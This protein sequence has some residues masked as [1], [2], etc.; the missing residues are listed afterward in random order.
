MTQNEHMQQTDEVEYSEVVEDE[1]NYDNVIQ[2]HFDKINEYLVDAANNS[3]I[4]LSKLIITKG[5]NFI[6]NAMENARNSG[7]VELEKFIIDTTIGNIKWL[8]WHMVNACSRGH[9]DI[10]KLLII[11]GAN[12]WDEGILAACEN[13]YTD[14]VELIINNKDNRVVEYPSIRT[15]NVDC[16]DSKSENSNNFSRTD[17]DKIIQL[18]NLLIKQN[19]E[20][21]VT[22]Y[23]YN[24]QW[25][26]CL[27]LYRLFTWLLCYIVN[28]FYKKFADIINIVSMFS[29][30]FAGIKNILK[31]RS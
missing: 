17:E 21:A 26:D 15:N 31:F 2:W 27:K 25:E 12:D 20:R 18:L 8:N 19:V 24:N 13:G 30:K 1:I 3:N 9:V 6:K 22:K 10:V 7:D 4:D 29:K 11:K 5:E 23:N 14:V 16:E 28:M